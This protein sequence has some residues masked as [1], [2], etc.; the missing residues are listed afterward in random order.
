MFELIIEFHGDV[1]L[2]FLILIEFI[3]RHQA[4]Q[5]AGDTEEVLG[6]LLCLRVG[7]I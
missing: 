3:L 5:L 4:F 7:W 6:A 1:L 2:Y